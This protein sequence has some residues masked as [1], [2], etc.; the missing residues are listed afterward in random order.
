VP[1]DL[2]QVLLSRSYERELA[3]D[4]GEESAVYLSKIRA[5]FSEDAE[6]TVMPL[7]WAR[8]CQHSELEPGLPGEVGVSNR[9]R[10]RRSLSSSAMPAKRRSM[11]RNAL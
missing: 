11:S 10:A 8:A 7:S 3:H 5:Q 6:A 1:D 9:C 2:R 4:L